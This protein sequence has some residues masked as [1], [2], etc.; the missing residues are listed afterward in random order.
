[1]VKKAEFSRL[2][3]SKPQTD[4]YLKFQNTSAL[5][6]SNIKSRTEK[7]SNINVVARTGLEPVRP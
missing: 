6:S 4:D 5:A 1:M 2:N 3:V 7:T